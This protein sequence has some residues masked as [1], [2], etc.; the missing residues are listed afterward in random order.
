MK[1][2]VVT[3]QGEAGLHAR[4]AGVL[5]KKAGEFTS[6]IT[7]EKEGKSIDAKRL[8]AILSLGAKKGDLITIT[9][10]GADEDSAVVA[11]KEVIEAN[12]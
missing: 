3:V 1:Q 2:L 6:K 10:D 5:V 7:I 8:L 11:I 12:H 4:P 9:A